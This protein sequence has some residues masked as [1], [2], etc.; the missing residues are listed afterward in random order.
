MLSKARADLAAG[1]V[2]LGRRQLEQLL[3][4]YPKSQSAD[5]ARD[6]L[7]RLQSP[8][9]PGLAVSAREEHPAAREAPEQTERGSAY[10][11]D[12]STRSAWIAD[13]RR[14]QKAGELR[15]T[16]GDRIFFDVGAAE[17]G[18]KARQ[19]LV[20][21]AAWLAREPEVTITIESHADD[22]GSPAYNR[23]LSGRRAEAVR[24][25]LVEHGVAP[26]RMR[27]ASFGR[28]RPLAR[29]ADAA[30]AAQNRRVVTSIEPQRAAAILDPASRSGLGM[31]PQ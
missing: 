18:A 3:E 14:A 23:E 11:A 2:D 7:A 6:I 5:E 27:I 24:Q 22:G 25:L 13:S 28:D 26:D 31:R 19:V 16:T 12:R 20:A 1:Y 10:P 8:D 29:C 30:C 21:Q 4:V 17:P 9:R 15:L